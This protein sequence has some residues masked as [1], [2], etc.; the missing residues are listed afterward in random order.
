MFNVPRR[1]EMGAP[2]AVIPSRIPGRP[3]FRSVY[4][5][6]KERR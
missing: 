5:P 1:T 4:H 6:L 3:P 2:L